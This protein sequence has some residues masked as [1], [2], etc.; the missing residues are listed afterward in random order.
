MI[1]RIAEEGQYE[2]PGSLL[3]ELNII[4]NKI[5]DLVAR[6]KEEE[7]TTELSKLIHMI[8]SNGKKLDDSELKESDIIVPP[9]DLTLKEARE[10]FTGD[11]LIED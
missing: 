6:E 9:D 4:D 1:I 8:R 7:Y 10:I 3:D 5:V 11:G 2:V